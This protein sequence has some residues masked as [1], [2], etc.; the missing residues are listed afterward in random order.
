GGAV[1]PGAAA[2]AGL[3]AGDRG[4][5]AAADLP[6]ALFTTH[7]SDRA[8]THGSDRAICAVLRA[9]AGGTA[10][11]RNG[12]R[13]LGPTPFSLPTRLEDQPP[14]RPG[15]L[16]L[17]P[18]WGPPA[19]VSPSTGWSAS[20][21]PPLPL[22]LSFSVGFSVGFS[23]G[24][25]AFSLG[26]SD[27]SSLGSSEGSSDGSSLGSSEG[28]SDGSSLGSSDGSSEG[29]SVG[30]GACVVVGSGLGGGV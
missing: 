12:A 29:S 11:C 21:P 16:P 22:P 15:A 30:C 13:P 1:E 14:P 9:L 25:V 7:G 2:S 3:P 18:D 27:G 26:S 28:S 19:S 17:L 10:Q 8:T 20:S 4:V 6:P 23:T 5:S 24:S